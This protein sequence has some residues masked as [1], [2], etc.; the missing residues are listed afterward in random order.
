MR[1]TPMNSHIL[2]PDA[3]QSKVLDHRRGRLL[4]TGRAGTGKTEVLRERFAR[5]IEEGADPER[6]ALIVRTRSARRMAR[7]ALLAR[8]S[9]SLP[10]VKALTVH[11]LAHHVIAR[12][13]QALE[14]DRP[15][16]VLTALDQFSKVRELLGGERPEDWA[17]YGRMLHL[18]GFADEVRQFL[19]RA[20]ESLVDPDEIMSRAEVLG[21]RGW[22]ELA[23]FY[24]RYIQILGDEGLVDFAGLINQAAAGAPLGDRLF[25]HLLVD[26]YQDATIAEEAL[27]VQLAPESLVVAGDM[28]SHV[29]SFQGATN[30][31]LGRF[32]QIDPSTV[33]VELAT[34]HRCAN[35]EYRAWATT[36]TSEEHSAVARE[37]RRTHLEDE[38][39]WS[40]I[41]VVVRRHGSHVGGL[42]R[43]LDDAG[44][45]RAPSEGGLSLLAEPA[46][47]PFILALRWLASPEGRDGLVESL[48]VSDLAGLSPAAA[49]GLVRAAQAS[50]L[51]PS[52]AMECNEGLDPDEARSLATL[53]E[54][55]A[56]AQQVAG[57]SILDAFSVLWRR[58]PCAERMVRVAEESVEGR[59]DL[60][61]VLAFSEAV[62]RAGERAD[63]STAAFV[64]LLDAGDEQLGLAALP[65]DDEVEGVKVLTAHGAAG[66]EFDTVIVV[67]VV[68]GNFPSLSRPEP[69]F[70]PAALQAPASQSDRNRLRLEDERRL[71]RLVTSRARRRVVFTAGDS[72]GDVAAAA[73][74]SR[75]VSE[76]GVAWDHAGPGAGDRPLSMGEAAASWRRL[77]SDAGEPRPLR[78]AALAGLLTLGDA[79]ARWWFQRDWTGTDRPLH[80]AIRVSYSK[81]DTLE[82]CALQFVLNEEL[83]LEGRAGY[84]AWVGH[85]VHKIIEDCEAGLIPRNEEGLAA[86]A[87]DRWRA[88]EFPSRAVSEAFRRSVTRRM[89]PAWLATYGQTEALARELHFSFEL[90]GATVSGYI[91]RVGEVQ[92]GGSQITDYKTGKSR[93][94]QADDNL[95]LGIYYLAVNRAEE[96]QQFRPVKAV[97]LAF[98]KE[99]RA[100]GVVRAQL[101]LSSAAQ[102]EFAKRMTERLRGLIG[103]VQELNRTETYRPNP[104]A[105]CRYC[106]FKTLCP[107][108]PEGKELFPAGDRSPA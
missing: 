78:L 33:R 69:M 47:Q 101:G 52:G 41:A 71:F 92:T 77:L 3:Q 107:L 12:R 19:M 30:V 82:N 24:R 68:E 50:G 20:Q 39:S 63:S 7:R 14:Y 66:L 74:R 56:E 35:P 9:R 4:V 1:S 43:A 87:E 58:L 48:L 10:D 51:P 16:E 45:P 49:R 18:R 54:V 93:N 76:L 27:I 26:D 100:D 84:Y 97:E 17:T 86:A 65:S 67:D 42:L 60:D 25:D 32:A 108:W 15:P 80:E 38:V 94:A 2:A 85:L 98:L 31:P 102:H 34:P 11:G 36:H 23:G 99:T 106:D 8:L 73:S 105:N 37:L 57:H 79:P 29:F 62:A 75:F 96:L 22:R 91:D 21:L 5:L 90:E 81:L 88:Q 28:E 61:A 95:Q 44:I 64:E 40:Q 103:H 55:L 104:S 83:G 13:Y 72:H 6:V 53:R 59:R 89:L 70:D 46:A